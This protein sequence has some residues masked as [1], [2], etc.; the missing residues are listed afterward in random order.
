MCDFSVYLKHS[1]VGLDNEINRKIVVK[2][3]RSDVLIRK[4]LVIMNQM[5]L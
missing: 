2:N 1:S 4:M 5:S 3:N